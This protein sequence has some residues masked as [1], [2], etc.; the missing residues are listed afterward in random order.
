MRKHSL[1]AITVLLAGA[2]SINAVA[3]QRVINGTYPSKG[4]EGIELNIAVGDAKITV[5]DPGVIQFHVRLTPRRG[6][7]F[8]SMAE[9]QEQVDAAQLNM[10]P[11][12]KTLRL[13]IRSN[14]QNPKFEATW[15]ISIPARLAVSVRT[16]V[17]DVTINGVGGAVKVKD[18]VGDVTVTTHGSRLIVDTGVG[19]V[20]IRGDLAQF[21]HVTGAA[22]VGSATLT[23][24]NATLD[25]SGM[26]GKRLSWTGPGPGVMR[27]KAGVGDVEISL[28]T[29]RHS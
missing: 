18:G 1:M 5:G 26:V 29:P 10:T 21:G 3:G 2:V 14:S 23:P 16:G 27:I 12:G 28:A 4:L 11:A 17:G 19:D 24:P 8:S 9:A 20:T 13:S 7:V 15:S 6:G 25:G 22:G